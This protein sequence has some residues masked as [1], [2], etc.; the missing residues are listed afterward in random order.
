MRRRPVCGLCLLM[1]LGIVLLKMWELPF[2][3]ETPISASTEK[4]LEQREAVQVLGTVYKRA[5]SENTCSVYLKNAR[6]EAGKAEV[7]LGNIRVFL[8]EKEEPRM[9][10][11]LLLSGKLE[12]IQRPRNPGEFDGQQYYKCRHIYYQLKKAEIKESSAEYSVCREMLEQI[13]EHLKEVLEETAGEEQGIFCAMLLGDKGNLEQEIKTR[14]QMAGIIHIMAISGLHLSILGMGLLGILK[15][16]GLGNGMAGFLALAV[17]Y[18]YGLMTGGGVSTLRAVSMMMLSI[19]GKVLGRTYDMP[20]ALALAAILLLLDSPDYLFDSGFLLS[21]GA[22][23]GIGVIWPF[24]Q[25]HFEK[26]KPPV[27]G[28]LASLCVQAATLPVLLYFFYEVSVYGLLL[29]LLVIP[30]AGVVLLS[31]AAGGILG[32][33]WMQGARAVLLPGRALLKIYGLL[34]SWACRLPFCTWISGRPEIWQ[35]GIYYALLLGTLALWGMADR[36]KENKEKAGERGK[37]GKALLYSGLAISLFVG[38]WQLGYRGKAKLS[39][40]CLDV[41]QGDAVVITTEDGGAYLCDGGS[42]SKTSVGNYQILP[43][44]KSRGIA[45]LDGIFVSHTDSDHISGIKEL[46]EARA[47]N[48]TSLRIRRLY[49][50]DWSKAP[51]AWEELRALAGKARTPVIC[52]GRGEKLSGQGYEL[53]VLHPQ[54]GARIEDVNEGCLVLMLRAG[55]FRAIFTGDIGKETEKALLPC[56]EKCQ[57][58]KV[59][60]HGSANST[61]TEFLERV[62]PLAAIISCSENNRYGHPAPETVERLNKAGARI[63]ITK[64]C[65]AV[66]GTVEGE[67]LVLTGYCEQ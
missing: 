6:A 42:S 17:I 8:K 48:L 39:V 46:L 9:G 23:L 63:Y 62:Q 59:A 22:V 40:T 65:G 21:F 60:H 36:R 33:V 67:E 57:L 38:T 2:I 31:G 34:C 55:R 3:R 26:I 15:R 32:C 28:L 12:K 52:L 64:D 53:E 37:K 24:V 18:P 11:K 27:Q 54:K 49:L 51:E 44:L 30:T 47:E 5:N 66:T 50:P 43:Y 10:V 29:N 25:G 41:G 61:G 35:I 13:R 14:Y 56:L 16:I 58:L 7:L 20:T 45:V 4:I 19:G 1:M